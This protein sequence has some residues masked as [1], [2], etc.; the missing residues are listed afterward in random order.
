MRSSASSPR[1]QNALVEET[2]DG[3]AAL[4][5]RRRAPGARKAAHLAA[6]LL[7]NYDEYLIA[8]KDRPAADSSARRKHG[9][10]Q[11]R[12]ISP[13]PR[14]RWPAGRQL[15]AHGEG[16]FVAIEVAPYRKLTPVQTRAVMSAADCYGDFLGLP[17]TLSIV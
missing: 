12:R 8:Y 11:R 17:L 16:E 2:I 13:S 15:A 3:R 7:P 4:V 9:G 10:A 6:F 1:S 5:R 14:H